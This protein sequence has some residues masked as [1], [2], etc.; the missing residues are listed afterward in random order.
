MKRVFTRKAQAGEH[1][2]SALD[3]CGTGVVFLLKLF[4]P[5]FSEL[6]NRNLSSQNLFLFDP[7]GEESQDQWTSYLPSPC[8]W[9]QL[10]DRK[11][12]CSSHWNGSPKQS[13]RTP[14]GDHHGF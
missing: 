14:V 1:A 10:Q 5:P 4:S 13:T 7:E 11:H 3:Q 12:S 2:T 8:V 6:P 9:S